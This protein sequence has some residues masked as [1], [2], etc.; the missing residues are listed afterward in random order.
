MGGTTLAPR[1]PD[2]YGRT[3]TPS[4]RT[5]TVLA[6]SLMTVL[7]A[8]LL[9]VSI[10]QGSPDVRWSIQSTSYG[11]GTRAEIIATFTLPPGHRAI[12]TVTASNQGLATVG[13]S[14]VTVGPSSSRTFTATIQVP[15]MEPAVGA[16]IRA[17][18]L[19]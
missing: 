3:R 19:A 2:R 13:R 18:V 4:R 8:F 12:C 1:S 16:T 14:D 6:A 7:V 9:W 10:R 15:T 17:C 5:V 11:D